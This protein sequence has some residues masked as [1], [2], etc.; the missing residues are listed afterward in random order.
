MVRIAYRLGALQ[1]EII[2][3]CCGRARWARLSAV[4][5][6]KKDIPI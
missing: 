3:Q 4:L 6:V 5:E 2:S 1:M